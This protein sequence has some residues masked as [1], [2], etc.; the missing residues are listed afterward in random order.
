MFDKPEL[1]IGRTPDND[2]VI[3]NLAVSRLHAV[4]DF[5]QGVITHFPETQFNHASPMV[6]LV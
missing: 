2:I 6:D 3:D 1:R 4:L 5:E